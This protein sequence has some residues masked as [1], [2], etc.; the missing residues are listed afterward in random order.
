[1]AV[2][3]VEW[4]KPYTWGK[5]IS[6]D[7]NKVI[8]LNL[9]ADDNLIIYDEWDNEIYVDLQLPDWIVPTDAFPIWCN[10]G[11]VSSEDGWDVTGTIVSFQTTSGDNIKLLY[12]DD[13]T[14]WI[15]NGT[16]TFK[17]LLFKWDID[18]IVT[19]LTNYIDTELAKKQ[20]LTV[21]D[22]T[23]P[24]TPT[25]WLLWYDTSSNT[26][27]IYDG[28]TWQTAWGWGGWDVVVSSDSDNVLTTWAGLRAGSESDLPANPDSN[29]L[30]FTY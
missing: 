28:T 16:G 2:R 21:V 10:V 4:K 3:V 7:E 18:T 8:S 17:Q 12:A 9:R 13:W 27:K 15:D 29:V 14:L 25:E 19:N 24:S 6:I 1:M 11:R 5:A 23:A 26:L 30:Y 20:D 22:S